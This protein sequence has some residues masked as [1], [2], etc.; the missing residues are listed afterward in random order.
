[1]SVCVIVKFARD[2]FWRYSDPC[3]ETNDMNSKTI[4]PQPSRVIVTSKGPLEYSEAGSGPPILYFHGTGAPGNLVFD[5]ERPLLEAGFRL[6]VPNRPGYGKT[7]LS[8]NRSAA[9]C[10]DLAAELLSALSIDRAC[11][12]GCSGGG[13]FATAF[14]VRHAAK[15][16]CLALACAQVHRL[17][18][19][20]WLGSA[21]RWTFPFLANPSIRRW[22]FWMYRWQLCTASP[23]SF[24]KFESGPRY[25]DVQVDPRAN[26]LA[27]LALTSIRNCLVQGEGFD[28][29]FAVYLGEDVLEPGAFLGP[30][31]LVHDPL[32]PVAP[33]D[34]VQWVANC[35]PHAEQC[36]VS[37]GGHFV[38]VGKESAEMNRRRVLFCRNQF[39]P[40]GDCG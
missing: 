30:T 4:A 31:L 8:G 20:R 36:L 32:D 10:A 9:A 19:R 40:G 11:V 24:L 13:P 26:E 33:I 18:Q 37:A 38:W 39:M 23:A 28:N 12:M 3:Q 22:L 35:I 14:A 25:P 6:I 16:A 34:H 7:P 15:T 1:M 29:D 27:G 17:D 21:S 5:F 2:Y